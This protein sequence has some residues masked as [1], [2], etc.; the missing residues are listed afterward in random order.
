[1]TMRQQIENDDSLQEIGPL[2]NKHAADMAGNVADSLLETANLLSEISPSQY[3]LLITS[4]RWHASRTASNEFLEEY[5][6]W[7]LD[8]VGMK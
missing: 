2:V 3:G 1:M 8:N 6:K 7:I 4:L 5:S